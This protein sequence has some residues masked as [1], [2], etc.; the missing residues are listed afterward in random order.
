M[1]ITNRPPNQ[2][3]F[4]GHFNNALGKLP[5]QSNEI[6]LLG[7]FNFN[8]FFEGHYALQKYFKR[9][10]EAQLKN[11][12]LNLFSFRIKSANRKTNKVY[13][14]DFAHYLIF[15]ATLSM[16]IENWGLICHCQ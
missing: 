11:R 13:F 9:I 3:D 1:G 6:Y 4:I 7:D 12:L 5:F 16:V 15:I 14:A 10:K 2:V 8:L